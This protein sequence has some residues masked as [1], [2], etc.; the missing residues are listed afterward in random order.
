MSLKFL[1]HPGYVLESFSA[2][3]SLSDCDLRGFA[4]SP[5]PAQ[6]LT[7]RYSA[8]V[9]LP[10]GFYHTVYFTLKFAFEFFLHV[11]RTLPLKSRE[12]KL[13]VNRALFGDGHI[14]G[15]TSFSWLLS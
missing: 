14:T 7:P 3:I 1:Q 15:R 12:V 2:P 9:G 4:F 5:E 10:V 13:L 6:C 11:R 8:N